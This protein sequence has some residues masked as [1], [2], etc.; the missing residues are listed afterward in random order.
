VAAGTATQ[1]GKNWGGWV[2]QVFDLL[3]CDLIPH[4]RGLE[5]GAQNA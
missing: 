3:R 4:S 2:A 1:R 5:I